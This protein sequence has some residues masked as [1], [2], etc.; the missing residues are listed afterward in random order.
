MT[1]CACPNPDAQR[2]AE[3][4]YPRRRGGDHYTEPCECACHD[5]C[6]DDNCDDNKED[7]HAG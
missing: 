2:C 1:P 7:D 4:R 3:A 6:D 5:D